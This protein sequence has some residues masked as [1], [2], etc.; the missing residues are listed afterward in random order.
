MNCRRAAFTL[1]ELMVVMG[2]IGVLIALLLPAT[3]AARESARRASCQNNL[4]QIGIAMAGY[5]E[6][7]NCFPS[8]S[9]SIGPFGKYFGL[10]SAHVRLLP[11][12]DHRSLYNGVNFFL[13]TI[14]VDTLAASPTTLAGMNPGAINAPNTT[15]I[16]T[17]LAVFLCP[18]DGIATKGP[19]S[20][21]RGNAGVG[22][23]LSTDVEFP[24]S[25]N[26]LIAES[27]LVDAARVPDGL[28]HTA[29][30]S[31]RVRG[32]GQV[33]RPNPSRDAYSQYSLVL[34]ADDLIKSCR[35]AAREDTP[36]T[37]AEGRW[38]FWMGRDQTVYNHAQ[39]P[40]GTVPDCLLPLVFGSS[41]G[42]ATARGVHPGG[43][44]LLMG[45]GSTRFVSQSIT[46]AVWRGLGTRNGGELV[47]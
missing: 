34:T 41:I 14:P 21:Y 6:S 10:F 35:I 1:I 11:Y 4:R 40:N 26:G 36:A 47:D 44:N 18:S 22:P 43:V 39:T 23:T 27:Q 45:D 31:E 12:L 25:G 9:T 38:W 17:S 7:N 3:Q 5:H 42:M 15:V 46:Q 37:V 16:G 30:F 8:V 29:A 2:L 13:G 28:S 20:N 33:G 19:G 32:S 24:D